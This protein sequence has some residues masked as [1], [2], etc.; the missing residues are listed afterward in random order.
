MSTE[1]GQLVPTMLHVKQRGPSTTAKVKKALLQQPP[2]LLQKP[3]QLKQHQ[4]PDRSG[5][6]A[7]F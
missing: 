3:Q 5:L 6:T 4:R 2:P 7:R 1:I